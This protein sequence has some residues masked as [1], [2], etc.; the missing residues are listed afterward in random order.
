MTNTRYKQFLRSEIQRL[1]IKLK[2]TDDTKIKFSTKKELEMV[3]R[4]LGKDIRMGD[5]G[6]DI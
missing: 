5:F 4:R 1:E 2:N 3:K 6:V